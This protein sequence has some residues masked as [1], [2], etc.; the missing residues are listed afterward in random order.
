MLIGYA[1]V[2]THDQDLTVQREALERLGVMPERIY[3]DRGLT[4]TNRDRPGLRLAMAACRDGDTFVVTKLDRLARS[5]R[6]ARDIVDE[7]T[8]KNV[9][10]NLG[11]SIHDPNDPVGRLLFNVL[12]MVAEFESDLIRARTREGMQIAR[13]KG[14][15]RGRAPKLSAAQQALLVQVYRSGSHTIAELGQIFKVSRAT[16]YRTMQRHDA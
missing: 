8:A 2:S 1:R 14:R 3:T 9:K 4:G 13:A 7:L 16:V 10:L 11:G 5:L 6:D 12:A 15:L